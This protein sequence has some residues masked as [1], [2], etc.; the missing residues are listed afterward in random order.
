MSF[1]MSSISIMSCCFKS[2]SCFSSVLGIQ[3]LLWWENWVLMLPNSF[4]F[5][6]YGSCACLLP[7]GYLWCWLVLFSLAGAC[8]SNGP[9]SLCPH[10]WETSSLLV[11]SVCK[12]LW[13]HPS[14]R[15]GWLQEG[16]CP[17][18]STDS[19]PSALLAVPLHSYWRESR[20]LTS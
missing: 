13:N 16:S 6:W 10:S 2:N 19:I 5:C 9:V 20:A 18:C 7:S 3:D 1:L 12:G 4:G 15:C 17:R 11:V 14:P 8:T